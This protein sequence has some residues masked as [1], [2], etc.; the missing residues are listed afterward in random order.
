V[1]KEYILYIILL[2]YNTYIIHSTKNKMKQIL[3]ITLD[4]ETLSWVKNQKECKSVS[5][6]VNKILAERKA[7]K[8]DAFFQ[9]PKIIEKEN[10][11]KKEKEEICAELHKIVEE[12]DKQERE[13]AQE[14]IEN[15]E[16]E[17]KIEK[18]KKRE[19]LGK[20][21]MSEFYE[22]FKKVN[23]TNYREVDLL[24]VRMKEGGLGFVNL[25]RLLLLKK[26]LRDEESQKKPQEALQ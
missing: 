18:E 8:E 21:V 19:Q 14:V 24:G 13:K 25:P 12:G 1:N 9:L 6:F 17:E 2:L 4:E 16:S 10:K 15:I 23:I 22:D 26:I 11:I 5:E 20:I 3:N 7:I